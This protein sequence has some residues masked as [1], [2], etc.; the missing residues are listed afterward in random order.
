[1]VTIMSIYG[2]GLSL[3]LG[4][5]YIGHGLSL[6]WTRLYMESCLRHGAAS[7]TTSQTQR[8]PKDQGPW[9]FHNLDVKGVDWLL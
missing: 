1:M 6:S 7:S 9:L 8:D 5:I 4:H 3:S 2:H